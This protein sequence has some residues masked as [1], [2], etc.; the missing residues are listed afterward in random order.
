[1]TPQCAHR[2]LTVVGLLH[3]TLK[4][5][6]FSPVILIHSKP[7]W[8]CRASRALDFCVLG[9]GGRKKLPLLPLNDL[10]AVSGSWKSDQK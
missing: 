1:M 8:F 9:G 3:K 5:L 7:V 4:A 10:I 2:A 6:C